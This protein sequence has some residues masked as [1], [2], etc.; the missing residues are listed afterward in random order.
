MPPPSSPPPAATAASEKNNVAAV[1]WRHAEQTPDRVA[2]VVPPADPRIPLDEA[3]CVTF[4]E[5]A[6]RSAIFAAGMHDVGL[7]P[8]DRIALL[9]PVSVD[10]YALALAMFSRHLVAVL[11]DG[12]MARRRI[13]A[14]LTAS[15]AKA[16]VSVQRVLKWWPMIPALWGRRRIAVDI[17]SARFGVQPLATWLRDESHTMPETWPAERTTAALIGFT[18]GSTGTPKGA[19]RPHGTLIAQHR[20]LVEEFPPAV[21]D[22]DMPCFPAVALHNLCAGTPTVLP[23]GDLRHPA[24]IDAARVVAAMHKWNVT[25]ISGAPAYMA[26][27]MAHLAKCRD[28]MAPAEPDAK[29]SSVLALPALRRI[30]VGGAAVPVPLAARIIDLF[31]DADARIVYGSTEAEPI[32]SV[33]MRDA[34]AHS[35]APKAALP[36]TATAAVVGAGGGHG[37]YLVGTEADAATVTI[38]ALESSPPVDGVVENWAVPLGVPGEWLVCGSHVVERYVENPT[39]TAETKWRDAQGRVWHRTGDVGWRDGEGRLWLL[40]RV[41]DA[42]SIGGKTWWPY[43]IESA[44][45]MIPGVRYAAFVAD[46]RP[47]P[48]AAVGGAVLVAELAAELAANDFSGPVGSAGPLNSGPARRESVVAALSALLDSFGLANNVSIALISTMPTDAR[49]NSRIDRHAVRRWL[50]ASRPSLGS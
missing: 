30:V 8:G 48:T 3:E 1:V 26:H 44:A 10:F 32:A 39:A 28:M 16:V 29:P 14:A 22:V 5:L 38:V 43:P 36:T 19:D 25:S 40:G 34:V 7:R 20:A 50:L 42:V 31:P 2:L 47:A 46:P 17:A 12:A 33:S 24:K 37:G 49:H 41:A 6:R 13:V 4:A 11:I 35:S 18:S 9:A 15:R 23:P 21:D 45:Q 27:L